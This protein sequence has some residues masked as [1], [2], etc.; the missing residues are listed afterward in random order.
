M[1]MELKDI[2]SLDLMRGTM[3]GSKPFRTLNVLERGRSFRTSIS[4]GRLV[5]VK[6]QFIESMARHKPYGWTMGRK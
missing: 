5:R 1:A 6:D 4:S 2:W 3:Y